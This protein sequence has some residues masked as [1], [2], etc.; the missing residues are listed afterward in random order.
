MSNAPKEV[1]T[2]LNFNELLTSANW[3]RGLAPLH[4]ASTDDSSRRLPRR[5][6]ADELFTSHINKAIAVRSN[7]RPRAVA[8]G[9]AGRGGLPVSRTGRLCRLGNGKSLDMDAAKVLC[10]TSAKK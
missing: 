10:P 2:S 5:P 1:F 4:N 3:R 7:N 8:G 6:P 9:Q